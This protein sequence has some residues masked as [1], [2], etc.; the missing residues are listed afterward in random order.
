[1]APLDRVN[2]QHLRRHFFLLAREAD[3]ARPTSKKF[4][5]YLGP[6]VVQDQ[7]IGVLKKG[8]ARAGRL[9]SLQFG[10]DDTPSNEGE[11]EVKARLVLQQHGTFKYRV[12]VEGG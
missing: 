7:L 8:D 9:L 12:V 5:R 1:G 10:Q 2:H 11:V 3:I 4:E 6:L